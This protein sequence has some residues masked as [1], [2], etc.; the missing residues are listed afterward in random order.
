LSISFKRSHLILAP[1]DFKERDK[2]IDTFGSLL[3]KQISNQA[4]FNNVEYIFLYLDSLDKNYSEEYK[5]FIEL[6]ISNKQFTIANALNNKILTEDP[7]N[8]FGLTKQ[9]LIECRATNE[10]EIISSINRLKD[11][12]LFEKLLVL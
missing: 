1:F 8:I 3:K 2:V 9:L 5:N 10:D 11:F 6:S 7:D 4:S 12:S